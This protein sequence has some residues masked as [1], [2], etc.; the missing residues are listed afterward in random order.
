VKI[1]SRPNREQSIVYKNGDYITKR[2]N[3]DRV[4]GYKNGHATSLGEKVTDVVRTKDRNVYV[5]FDGSRVELNFRGGNPLVKTKPDGTAQLLKEDSVKEHFPNG[6]QT[7]YG[8]VKT[9]ETRNNGETNYWLADSKRYAKITILGVPRQGYKGY[10]TKP[11]GSLR[12]I[13]TNGQVLESMPLNERGVK[14]RLEG[15]GNPSSPMIRS[16][17]WDVLPPFP[18]RPG[19]IDQSRR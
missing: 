7:P 10:V 13:Q 6:H 19:L 4:E 15:V 16:V 14:D 5:L 1:E 9:L 8:L 11:D 3:G 18:P 2:P 12:L 17:P